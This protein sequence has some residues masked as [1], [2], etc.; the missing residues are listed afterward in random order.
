MKNKSLKKIFKTISSM[1]FGAI[2]GFG[3]IMFINNISKN[4]D[5]A[6]FPMLAIMI[7]TFY[8]SITLHELGHFF[9]FILNGIQIRMLSISIFSFIFD[10]EKWRLRLNRN[11][12]GVGGIA[13]PNLTVISNEEEFK[14]AQKGYANAIIAAPMVTLLLAIIGALLL[15]INFLKYR[16]INPYLLIFGGTLLLINMFLFFTCFAKSEAVYG[17]FSAYSLYKNDDFF[18]ALMMYQ[19]AMFSIDY[20]NTRINNNYLKE[21]LLRGFEERAKDRKTDLFTVS[22]A[23]TFIDEYLI[24]IMDELPKSIVY[25]IDYYYENKNQIIEK[26]ETEQHRLLLL[27]IAYYFEKE[28]EH[29]KAVDIYD[30]FIKTLSK[31]PV[32]DYWKIQGEQII[33]KKDNSKYLLDKKNIKPSSI[34]SVFK[35]LDGLYHD[36]LIL[37]QMP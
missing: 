22:C 15:L 12:I 31:S 14:K 2:G 30:S 33:F 36:E 29:E 11:N 4:M 8:I 9:A 7:L 1:L 25:Y 5:V 19:Y 16:I 20:E 37:N 26:Q 27:H 34:Y 28:G 23:T 10:G 17:D 32:F 6:I 13:V 24:G 35:Q 21:I 3:I 18:A